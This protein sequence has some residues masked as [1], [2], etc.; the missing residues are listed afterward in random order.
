MAKSMTSMPLLPGSVRNVN[1]YWLFMPG[2]AVTQ[3]L[4]HMGKAKQQLCQWTMNND[5][6]GL[7]IYGDRLADDA[8]WNQ[9]YELI[10]WVQDTY[11]QE[12]L[13]AYH[14]H[15][16]QNLTKH[17]AISPTDGA[18]AQHIRRGHQQ[19]IMWRAADPTNPPQ[20]DLSTLCFLITNRILVPCYGVHRH[21]TIRTIER[22]CM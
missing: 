1:S 17:P 8:E 16:P 11:Y 13:A 7:D 3:C 21:H 22:S 6:L 5:D 18:N 12:F 20:V 2:V 14:F 9:I 19:P 4:T 15:W 10:V